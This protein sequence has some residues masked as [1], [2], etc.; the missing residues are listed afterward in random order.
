MTFLRYCDGI[1]QFTALYPTSYSLSTQKSGICSIVRDCDII[2]GI[3][4]FRAL[5]RVNTASLKDFG[6]TV[7]PC[8]SAA[9]QFAAGPKSLA[10][11][12]HKK[13]YNLA[14]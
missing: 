5:C 9:G 4:R 10:A 7:N 13:M 3:E 2:F 8:K 1:L 12:A 11:M 14:E 6:P